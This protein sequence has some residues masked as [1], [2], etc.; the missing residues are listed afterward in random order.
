MNFQYPKKDG[1]RSPNFVVINFT[2]KIIL[3]GGTQYTGEIK[4]AGFQHVEFHSSKREEQNVLS[5]HCAANVGEKEDTAL[6]FE[7]TK[8]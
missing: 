8:L 5:M 1:V 6:F 7:R 3:I 2:Q 4:K